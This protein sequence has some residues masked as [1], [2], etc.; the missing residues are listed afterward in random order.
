[1]QASATVL[2]QRFFTYVGSLVESEVGQCD[3]QSPL[4]VDRSA[5][6][7]LHGER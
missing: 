7:A 3:I 2:G 1:M 5:L 4:A 6:A